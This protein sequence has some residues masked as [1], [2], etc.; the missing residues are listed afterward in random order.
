MDYAECTKSAE[1][2]LCL[3]WYGL[4]AAIGSPAGAVTFAIKKLDNL[5]Y[6][7]LHT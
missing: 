6:S 5:K 7:V 2:L 3:K 1:E 4:V